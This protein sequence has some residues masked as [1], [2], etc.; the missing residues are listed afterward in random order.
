M[1]FQHMN[2][3]L[4]KGGAEMHDSNRTLDASKPIFKD[5][6]TKEVTSAEGILVKLKGPIDV[7]E[8]VTELLPLLGLELPH[9]QW[10]DVPDSKCRRRYSRYNITVHKVEGLN[11]FNHAGSL[12]EIHDGPVDKSPIVI[13]RFTSFSEWESLEAAKAALKVMDS[14]WLRHED[15]AENPLP[16]QLRVVLCHPFDPWYYAIDNQLIVG[17]I[18]FPDGFQEDP[19]FKAGTPCVVYDRDDRPN[20]KICL[21]CRLERRNNYPSNSQVHVPVFRTVYFDDGTIW[22]ESDRIGKPP[23]PLG[24]NEVWAFDVLQRV[25]QSLAGGA[26]NFEVPLVGGMKFIGRL[27]G[28]NGNTFEGTYHARISFKDGGKDEGY[29]DFNPTPELPTAE[30]FLRARYERP[31]R[32]FASLKVTLHKKRHLGQNWSGYLTDNPSR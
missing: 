2:T 12:F 28:R 23:R 4:R 27:R 21:G 14:R 20:I 17:D 1:T 16:G 30:A 15:I 7:V 22:N 5:V 10:V 8:K 26:M 3:S 9:T 13:D 18:V 6:T 11:D 32:E 24:D 25:Q 19:V 29:F 31:R